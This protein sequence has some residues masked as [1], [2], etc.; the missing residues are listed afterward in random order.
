[1]IK[2]RKKYRR[3]ASTALDLKLT[4]REQNPY[5]VVLKLD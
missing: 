5:R 1:M 2:L 4:L 3:V